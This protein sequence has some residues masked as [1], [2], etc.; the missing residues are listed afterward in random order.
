ME[1]S[2]ERARGPNPVF[3]QEAGFGPWYLCT[4]ALLNRLSVRSQEVR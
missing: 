1:T 4:V 2:S 3:Y